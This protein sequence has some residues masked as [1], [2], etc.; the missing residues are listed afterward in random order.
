MSSNRVRESV[1]VAHICNL[2]FQQ[3]TSN[4][5]V[6]RPQVYDNT[7]ACDHTGILLEEMCIFFFFSGL[8]NCMIMLLH[9][10]DPLLIV[11]SHLRL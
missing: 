8:L 6:Y 1:L 7:D 9:S 3:C 2:V 10:S 4:C 11:R 5:L